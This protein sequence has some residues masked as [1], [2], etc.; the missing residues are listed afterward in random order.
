M[1]S[2]ANLTVE[3]KGESLP[4]IAD[5]CCGSGG[6]LIESLWDVWKK[7]DDIPSLT[8]EKKLTIKNRFAT[9]NIVGIDIG[10]EP[11]I[12]KLARINMFLHGDGGSRIFEA[13]ALN[14]NIE[15]D[16]RWK[17][18]YKKDIGE[19]KELLKTEFVD[20]VITNPP[21]SKVYETKHEPEKAILENYEIAKKRGTGLTKSSVKSSILF[22][23][24]YFDLLKKGGRVVA[25]IDDSVLGGKDYK[26][27]R[28][29]IREKFIIE[30]VI[31]LP[32]DAFQRSKARVKTSIVS[33]IKKSDENEIQGNIFMYYCNWIGIDDTPRQRPL[34]ID[35][36]NREK[37]AKEVKVVG[38][39][40]ND[41]LAGT[42][43]KK[44]ISKGDAVDDRMDVKSC[45][46]KPRKLESKWKSLSKE[47]VLLRELVQ[48]YDEDNLADSDV[49][50]TNEV[51]ET[52]TLLKVKYN[53]TAGYGEEKETSDIK[54]NILLK[55]SAG[56][57]V[58]SN[59][60]AVHGAIAVVTEDYSGC[61]ISS[62][63]TLCR[64]K[65][66]YDPKLVWM[67]AR[68]PQSR[69]DLILLASGMGRT[70]VRWENA[71]ELLL[72]LP[73]DKTISK[74]LR[75]LAKSEEYAKKARVEKEEAERLIYD[76]LNL[77]NKNSWALINAFKPPK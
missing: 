28:Q 63:Y 67:L 4:V 59:I 76:E 46:P 31:S 66:G 25:I 49:L 8:E 2:I 57:I 9:Q 65:D 71:R 13:D 11:P 75:S 1:I 68:S 24:R 43:S 15:I 16:Q 33:L 52:V 74:A 32:G 22:I 27:V 34:P 38:Q 29:Y 6:F 18:E 72:A 19:L 58:I 45:L 64:A 21:F 7:I 37:A 30:A 35:R 61:Y 73:E 54:Y 40:F 17:G 3:H 20:V 12:A 53:G 70:R 14:K 5:P 41:F 48:V 47:V 51:E 69:G 42:V 56:D 77:D 44:W 62:E 36:K 23:E 60:N 55:V 50:Y 26:E 39:L 10:K